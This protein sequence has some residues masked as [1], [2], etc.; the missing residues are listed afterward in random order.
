MRVEVDPEGYVDFEAPIFIREHQLEKFIKG[1]EEIFGNVKVHE[2]DELPIDKAPPGT[3]KKW[4]P[5]E[6]V[7]LVSDKSHEE[8]ASILDRESFSVR[9]KRGVW[10]LPFTM[11]ARK[12]GY[13]KEGHWVKID[14][15]IKE[16][17][18][19]K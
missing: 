14:E 5:E 18:S 3:L 8:I 15:A 16:Y 13:Y 19:S 17:E 12:K 4:T 2:I 1:L 9:S 11:W 6:L 10:L 7:Y